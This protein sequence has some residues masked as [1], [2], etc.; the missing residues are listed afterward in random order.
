MAVAC[1]TEPVTMA[2]D[3][4]LREGKRMDMTGRSIARHIRVGVVAATLAGDVQELMR[5]VAPSARVVARRFAIPLG[6]LPRHVENADVEVTLE[7]IVPAALEQTARN[8]LVHAFR[9]VT[10]DEA[11]MSLVFLLPA[12]AIEAPHRDLPKTFTVRLKAA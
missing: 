2:D 3:A 10:V 5:A 7:V 9:P 11:D 6:A 8:R 1:D 4:V 12:A